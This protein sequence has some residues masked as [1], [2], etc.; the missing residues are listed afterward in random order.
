MPGVPEG[1]V[2][3]KKIRDKI[4]SN[5]DVILRLHASI[6]ISGCRIFVNMS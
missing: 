4:F 2:L 1:G 3:E 6:E 5:Y